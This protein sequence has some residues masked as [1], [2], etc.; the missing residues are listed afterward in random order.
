MKSGLQASGPEPNATPTTR[1]REARPCSS[2]NYKIGTIHNAIGIREPKSGICWLARRE[3]SRQGAA[4]NSGF[5]QLS[6]S[7]IEAQSALIE[8]SEKEGEVSLQQGPRQESSDQNHEEQI[9]AC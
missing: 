7:S 2:A 4:S 8:F 3:E 9:M 5:A 1:E 6:C